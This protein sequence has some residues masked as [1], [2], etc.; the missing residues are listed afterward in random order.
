[1]TFF[2]NQP[3]DELGRVAIPITLRKKLGLEIDDMVSIDATAEGWITLRAGEMG[4]HV[5]QLS[6]IAQVLLP[7][8]IR[9]ELG[10]ECPSKLALYY[11]DP[12]LI[13][14]PV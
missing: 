3:I 6:E 5:K 1:M 10:I 4:P 11:I 7:H 2:K 8:G 9:R 14:K 13:L 12:Q